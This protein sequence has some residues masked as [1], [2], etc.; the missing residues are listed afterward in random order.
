VLFI[1]IPMFI[2]VDLQHQQNYTDRSQMTSFVGPVPSTLNSYIA[3]SD[4]SERQSVL[5]ED[6]IT[7]W[8]QPNSLLS[9]YSINSFDAAP[10]RS[11]PDLTESITPSSGSGLHYDTSST[12]TE[13]PRRY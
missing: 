7:S 9:E 2:D 10:L 12:R 1:Y 11:T 6:T 3:R 5:T 8:I 4:V 13:R